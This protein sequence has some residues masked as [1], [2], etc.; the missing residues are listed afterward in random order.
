MI[1]KRQFHRI[2]MTETCSLSHQDKLYEGQLDNISLNGA[3][4]SFPDDVELPTGAIC[5][6][7][8]YLKDD[9]ILKLNV[10]IIHSNTAMV[11]MRFVPLDEDG[12]H[13]LVNLV[14]KFTT[15][16]AKLASELEKLKWHIANYLRAS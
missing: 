12:Q 4:A 2:G 11:G 6:L 16:P 3:V 10:E 5:L 8:I 13:R 1:E 9:S 15:E 7:T 14:E